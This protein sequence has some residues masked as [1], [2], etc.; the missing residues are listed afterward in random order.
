MD[1]IS[2]T[3]Y[4]AVIIVGAGIAG[5]AA[6]NTLA[7]NGIHFIIVE[8]QDNVG[9][10][11]K[12]I[13]SS[14]NIAVDL[15][16]QFVHGEK[17]N[18]VYELCT[19]LDCLV[20]DEDESDEFFL[21]SKH[22]QVDSELAKE[23]WDIREKV[24]DKARKVKNTKKLFGDFLRENYQKEMLSTVDDADTR[25]AFVQWLLKIEVEDNG[26]QSL[27][28]INL[29]EFGVFETL[30]GDYMRPLK[31]SFQPFLDYL[32]SMIPTNQLRLNS[33]VTK[34]EYLAN[35]HLSII[36]VIDR[37]N[38]CSK[39]LSC[40]H[41]IWTT[42]IGHLKDNFSQIFGTENKLI[43]QKQSA[44][45]NFGFGTVNK[46][47]LIYPT[48]M[49]FWPN[50]VAG[51]YLLEL[52]SAPVKLSRDQLSFLAT[53]EVDPQKAQ[54]IMD[55]IVYV[56]PSAA[57]RTVSFSI[58]GQAALFVEEMS[59]MVLCRLCHGILCHYLEITNEDKNQ[60]ICALKSE[61]G[62]NRFIRGSYS[63]LS[64]RSTE[65]DQQCLREP[66]APD[67]V[68]RV[69]FAGEAMHPRFFSTIHGAFES[70]SDAAH[71]LIKTKK[72]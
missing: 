20:D 14:D 53:H 50:N 12:T 60:P 59:E 9:G 33:E 43:E 63:F 51:I 34:V 55:A 47:V 5:L 46:V 26:C 32:L 17:N 39:K 6:A 45:E 28:D 35:K 44:I 41:I 15:G 70:G 66:Y 62:K 3:D 54:C 37:V 19:T 16:A 52:P 65:Q 57:F 48:P 29:T 23:V 36:E 22:K 13:V 72:T 64:I 31:N 21:T 42:S 38:G 11:V 25:Q 49:N 4:C 68:P 1:N 7:S 18:K 40:D 8:A 10:R 67:G 71:S 24:L 27:N 69:I 58:A 30:D 2:S 56:C 61:W